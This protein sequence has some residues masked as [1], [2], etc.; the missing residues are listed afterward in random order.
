[1][2]FKL[3]SLKAKTEATPVNL[4]HPQTGENLVD[5]KGNEIKVHVFGKASKKHRDFSD[6]RLK[7][8]LEKQKK[9]GKITPQELT[10][11]KIR[12]ESIE[13]AVAMSSHIENMV[14]DDDK[15]INSPEAFKTIY[16]NPEYY[17]LLEQVNAAIENDSNFI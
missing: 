11:E 16:E 8:A 17:W 6:S 14:G 13:F 4:T 2:S 3:S 7:S 5:D 9:S 15:P 1:M 12:S 10:V